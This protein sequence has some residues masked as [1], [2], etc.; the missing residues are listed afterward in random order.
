MS[1]NNRIEGTVSE[2]RERSASLA[3]EDC[4]LRGEA[5]GGANNACSEAIAVIRLDQVQLAKGTGRESPEP[6]VGH[7]MRDGGRRI[8]VGLATPVAAIPNIAV[9]EPTRRL[10][11][12]SRLFEVPPRLVCPFLALRPAP[13]GR[14]EVAGRFKAWR[15]SLR[16][17]SVQ[18]SAQNCCCQRGRA[19]KSIHPDRG[20]RDN[21]FFRAAVGR[22]HGS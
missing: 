15:A 7:L 17:S 3:G 18:N 1:S 5:G 11:E 2:T 20:H 19:E 22:S 12:A 14:T 9:G 6:T 13:E 16:R 8:G 4:S 21:L 10:A